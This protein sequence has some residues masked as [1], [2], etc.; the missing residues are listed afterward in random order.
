MLCHELDPS[1][2]DEQIAAD[3]KRIDKDGDGLISFEEFRV[4]W[5][6]DLS[7]HDSD[8]DDDEHPVN[9]LQQRLLA[10]TRSAK[11]SRKP[12]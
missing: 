5:E 10:L 12:A 9:P 7:D 4:W 1:M 8:D 3:I 6:G 2:T 11:R